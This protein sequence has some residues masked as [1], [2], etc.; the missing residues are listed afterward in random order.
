M[1]KYVLMAF[2]LCFLS[3][4]SS[5]GRGLVEGFMDAQEK[6]KEEMG[7]TILSA[8]FSGLQ[9]AEEDSIKV[10]FVHGIGHHT[11]GY[12]LPFINQLALKMGMDAMSFDTKKIQMIDEKGQFVGHL[13]VYRFLNKD[14]GKSVVFYEQ[15]W[16]GITEPIKKALAYDTMSAYAPYRSAVNAQMKFFMN[17]TLP[18]TTIYFGPDGEKMINS[19]L[20][21]FCWMTNFDYEELPDNVEKFCNITA[22]KAIA[23]LSKDNFVFITN[24]LGSRITIDALQQIAEKITHLPKGNDKVQ[25]ALELLRQKEITIFMLANQLPLLQLGRKAPLHVGQRNDFCLP[26]GKNYHQR[27]FKLLNVVAISDPNDLLSYALEPDSADTYFDSAFCP[28]ISNV[29]ITTTP[30]IDVGIGQI[31]NPL[32]AHTNYQ[33]NPYILDLMVEGLQE[34]FIAPSID[35]KCQWILLKK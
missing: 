11:P 17:S 20:Q 34:G 21:S 15:T 5:F 24:S 22:Q 26:T 7:C 25:K 2:L 35:E 23:G 10:L 3:G 14:T 27:L 18:D 8:G 12:G 9:R 30:Q 29:S 16:S 19:S 31:A 13:N 1:K 33:K 28:V 32:F 6:K 4:C